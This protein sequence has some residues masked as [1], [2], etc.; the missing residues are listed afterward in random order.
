VTLQLAKY[1]IP[2]YI[3]RYWQTNGYAPTRHE[4]AVAVGISAGAVTD[5]V[6]LLRKIGVLE[7]GNRRW[8]NLK[9]KAA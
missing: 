4:I 6:R 2:D 1:Q 7:Q 5:Y 8:R 9:R 3:D